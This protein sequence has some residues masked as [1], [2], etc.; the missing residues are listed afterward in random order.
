MKIDHCIL[1]QNFV[2]FCFVFSKTE[3]KA[4]FGAKAQC[5][6]EQL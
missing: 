3:N 1:A 2:L 5:I 4:F 6:N